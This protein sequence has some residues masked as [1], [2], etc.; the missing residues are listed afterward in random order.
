MRM[1]SD[2]R[3][4]GA[5]VVNITSTLQVIETG[6]LGS[7]KKYWVTPHAI[8]SPDRGIDTT[9]YTYPGALDQILI[10]AHESPVFSLQFVDNFIMVSC[11]AAAW[12]TTRLFFC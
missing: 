1:T 3:T 8:E 2:H 4:P 10:S 6:A 5:H 9:G 7:F 12:Q 11:L